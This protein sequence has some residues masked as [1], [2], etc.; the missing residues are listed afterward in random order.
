[1]HYRFG[2]LV[3]AT[4]LLA[5]CCPL[6]V[7][8]DLP[9][10]PEQARAKACPSQRVIAI[11][12][13]PLGACPAA[14][15]WTERHLF[16]PPEA[17][18]E[19]RE[20]FGDPE[21]DRGTPAGLERRDAPAEPMPQDDVAAAIPPGLRAFCLY[22]RADEGAIKLDTLIGQGLVRADSD[23]VAVASAS[24][25]RLDTTLVPKLR[26][27]FLE[28][29]GAVDLPSSSWPRSRLTVI[30]SRPNSGAVDPGRSPH[31]DALARM[32]EKLLCPTATGCAA[33]VEAELALP[34]RSLSPYETHPN[35]GFIGPI[36][37]LAAAVHR[38]VRRWLADS[39]GAEKH[40]VLNLSL[41]WNGKLFNLTQ[42]APSVEACSQLAATAI[43]DPGVTSPVLAVYCALQDASCRGA[44]TFAAAGNR[45]WGPPSPLKTGA[46]HPA[47][48][49]AEPA[50]DSSICQAIL[51]EEP[52]AGTS[53]P[54]MPLVHAVG[55]VRA[56]GARLS[57]SRPHA[58]PRL[59]AFGDHAVVK[60]DQSPPLPTYTGTSVGTLVVAASA[61]AVWH[62][63][64]ELE[65]HEVVAQLNESGDSVA[66]TADLYLGATPP[67]VRRVTLCTAL[68]KA[69]AGL[70]SNCPAQ[71]QQLDCAA[72]KPLPI[73]VPAE[74]WTA[75]T[76][77]SPL[78][79]MRRCRGVTECAG[80]TVYF[81][82]RPPRNPCPQ[83]QF[84][85]TS[86]RPW[87]S[88]QPDEAPCPRCP[89]SDNS[90]CSLVIHIPGDWRYQG[91]D[92]VQLTDATL[93][94][95]DTIYALSDLLPDVEFVPGEPI[96]V[97]GIPYCEDHNLSDDTS[98]FLAFRLQHDNLEGPLSVVSPLLYVE[99]E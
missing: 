73:K 60:E 27:R 34:I 54:E 75:C 90:P 24:S 53:G 64:P 33:D 50:P 65:P 41:G 40:L 28:G 49:T 20:P 23:C 61:A 4:A 71:L 88:P 77:P 72:P 52:A 26:S 13:D 15:G 63:Q 80:K 55:G 58:E 19:P 91:Y 36:G 83:Y 74:P 12:T 87:S 14:A 45:S 16:A 29:A 84:D 3:V 31:G 48:W 99:N 62:Y 32:A 25:D 35:G 46:L 5:S 95:E 96:F 70:S 59:V 43:D 86:T 9:I 94:I 22:E 66:R 17:Q 30:D 81:R 21:A 47:A 82:G 56:S 11:K 79:G 85:D 2:I 97:E 6:N 69:C 68:D 8:V 39:L 67:E 18:G 1:M 98:M 76:G 57:N 78:G 89:A 93:E 92:D 42:D 7:S 10:S 38:A 44:L 37:E 51:D